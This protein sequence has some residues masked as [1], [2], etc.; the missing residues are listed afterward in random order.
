MLPDAAVRHYERQQQLTGLAL[1]TARRLWRQVGNDFD[2]SWQRVG[3]RLAALM[4]SMQRAVVADA[5]AYVPQVVAEVGLDPKPVATPMQA[6]LVGVASDGRD[7]ASLLY[8]PV[9]AAKSTVGAG[10]SVDAAHATGL[11]SLERIMQTQI[12]DAA[13]VMASVG[14]VVRPRVGGY[15]RMLNPPSCSRCAVLAGKWFR[16]NT[17]F[18]RHPRCDCRHIP[19]SEDMAGDLRTDPV[20]YFRSLPPSQQDSVFTKAGAEAIRDGAD[21]G[22]VVNARRGAN[23]LSVAGGRL[24]AEEQKMLRGGLDRGHLQRSDVYGQQLYT[25]TEG[26]TRRGIAGKRLGAWSDSTKRP[27][28]RY[29]S[30][31]V[32]RLM[33]ES[34]YEIA[35]DR[36]DAIRLLKRFGYVL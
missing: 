11:L 3:P 36:D 35:H 4:V 18:Q 34:I 30:A 17:G 8:E 32:P 19:A 23:G 13:R 29:R 33:P 20:A 12:A 24:T 26:V 5:A 14:I 10:G 7:L 15:V 21:L 28:Q 2:S 25:T 9:V 22:Q 6:S 31:N 16:W 27:G 1:V